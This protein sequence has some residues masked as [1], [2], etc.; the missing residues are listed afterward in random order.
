M[1]VSQVGIVYYADDPEKK[2]F[3]IVYPQHDDSELDEPAHDGNGKIMRDERGEPHGWHTFATDP[4][5]TAVMEKVAIGDPRATI[6]GT[7]F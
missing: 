6:T 7:P 4:S 5:R 1:P 2:V 3:R